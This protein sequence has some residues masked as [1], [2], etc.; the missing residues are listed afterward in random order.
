MEWLVKWHSDAETETGEIF[1]VEGYEKLQK[2]FADVEPA[3]KDLEN[4]RDWCEQII[5]ARFMELMRAT[6]LKAQEKHF[7]WAKIPIYF[8][9]HSYDFIVRSTT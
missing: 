8:T 4:A 7:A 6:H 2:A 9:E 1:I 3:T 5:I